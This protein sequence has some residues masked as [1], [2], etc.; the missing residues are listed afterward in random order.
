MNLCLE[1]SEEAMPRLEQEVAD[2]KRLQEHDE[3]D[4]RL[5]GMAGSKGNNWQRQGSRKRGVAKIGVG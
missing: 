4:W 1:G 5:V 2:G 3:G